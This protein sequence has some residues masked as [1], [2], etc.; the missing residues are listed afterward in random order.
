LVWLDGREKLSCTTLDVQHDLP[1][2]GLISG[3]QQP[4]STVKLRRRFDK[5]SV[6][7]Y[8][9]TSDY[10]V[11]LSFAGED[12]DFAES[13]ATE[14]VGQGICVFYGTNGPTCGG[15]IYQHLQAVYCGDAV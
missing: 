13:H 4:G 6:M 14:L 11:A 1:H 7:S 15:K 12:P 10:D 5:V 8:E 2:F 9:R 3:L